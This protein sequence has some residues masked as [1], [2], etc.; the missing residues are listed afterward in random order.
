M[1]KGTPVEVFSKLKAAFK[2]SDLY[3]RVLSTLAYL[4]EVLGYATRMKVKMAININP[5]S[6]F[7][8]AF[9]SGGILFTCVLRAKVKEV[10]AAG[11]RYDNLIQ[12][13]R[14]NVGDRQEERRAVGFSLSWQ[15]YARL[16]RPEL[17][18]TQKR[19]D[20]ESVNQDSVSVHERFRTLP[21]MTMLLTSSKARRPC[22]EYR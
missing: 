5:L 7:R 13:F 22:G 12:E 19:P 11:G 17:G 8:E 6:S 14:L 16:S 15:N 3:P 2:G 18:S 1:L 20:L 10:F 4:R 21:P 9:Y